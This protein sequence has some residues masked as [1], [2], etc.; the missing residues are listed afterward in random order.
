MIFDY[1]RNSFYAQAMDNLIDDSS[2]VMDLG[3]GLG[4][5]GFMAAA[6]GAKRVY[7]IDPHT[8]LEIAK[9]IASQNSLSERIV[10]I[11]DQAEKVKLPEQVDVILSVFTGNFLLEQD[12]L[13]SLFFARDK[14]LKPGG[15]LIPDRGRMW[16]VPVNMPEFYEKF[17]NCWSEAPQGISHDA[18]TPFAENSVYAHWFT[19][20]NFLSGPQKLTSLD[21]TR[22]TLAECRD[23]VAFMFERDGLLHGF[24]GWFDM[25]LDSAWLST[26]PRDEETHWRQ[27]FLP[28]TPR[29]I[30]AGEEL[31]LTVIRPQYGDWTW[32]YV[33]NNETHQH[34]SLLSRP[35][36]PGSVE[37]IS[38]IQ[39]PEANE[40]THITIELLQSF[41][42]KR[43]ITDLARTLYE[44]YP[45]VFSSLDDA[46]SF[47]RLQAKRFAASN[48][49]C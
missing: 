32:R 11:R 42:G 31:Q 41:T 17:I 28:M 19:D 47:V 16:I 35:L 13:P 44:R 1:R 43:T 40:L 45:H 21:F 46:D 24:L 49:E 8:N 39:K 4:I 26:G 12:L 5:L 29:R 36:T 9:Q 33:V 15:H 7:M 25:R 2:V 18:M 23:S 14:F 37:Q 30:N 10:F 48:E 22:A 20:C 6:R 38:N 3:A 27:V 34:S